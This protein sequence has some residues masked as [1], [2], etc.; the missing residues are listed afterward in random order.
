ML[1]VWGGLYLEGLIHG[2]AYFRN[3][4]VLHLCLKN[5][6]PPTLA[7]ELQ[8]LLRDSPIAKQSS[9]LYPLLRYK[10][11]L[12]ITSRWQLPLPPPP[13]RIS[14]GTQYCIRCYSPPGENSTTI[15][16]FLRFSR[17]LLKKPVCVSPAHFT[18]PASIRGI[19]SGQLYH[20]SESALVLV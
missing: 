20:T 1:P 14:Q 3:F 16:G 4:T 12:I 10:L 17:I 11:N 13:P 2:G 15:T 9:R 7:G 6:R 8:H 5:Y 19:L 18:H